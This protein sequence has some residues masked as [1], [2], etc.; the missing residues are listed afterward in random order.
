MVRPPFAGAGFE[1]GAPNWDVELEVEVEAVDAEDICGIVPEF[2][3]VASFPFVE[4]VLWLVLN[5]T[6]AEIVDEPAPRIEDPESVFE[7]VTSFGRVENPARSPENVFI[8]C[9]SHAFSRAQK[10]QE[11]NTN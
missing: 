4:G 10:V 6:H 9:H 11:K 7:S 1:V 5:D 2:E 3:A 8:A